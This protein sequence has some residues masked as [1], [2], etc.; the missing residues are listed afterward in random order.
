M[1]MS[2][3]VRHR[4]NSVMGWRVVGIRVRGRD[5]ADGEGVT[6]VE[7]DSAQECWDSDWVVGE[8]ERNRALVISSPRRTM[9]F[10]F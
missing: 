10:D 2:I 3:R 9:I 6:R 7:N 5:R 8:I 1:S 4:R